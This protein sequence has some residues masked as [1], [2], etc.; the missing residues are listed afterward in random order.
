MNIQ[1]IKDRCNQCLLCARD[2]VAGAWRIVN[3]EPIL[4]APE[5]CSRCG[6][7]VAVCPRSAIFHESMDYH[8]ITKIDIDL[9]KPDVYREIV[10]GRRSIRQYKKAEVPPDIIENILK[11][12]SHSPT[13]SNKQNVAYTVISDKAILHDLSKS[14]FGFGK[15]LYEKSRKGPGKV[16]YFILKSLFPDNINRYLDPMDYYIKE[17][18]KGRD[19]ILHGAP[20]LILVHGPEKEN[21]IN[22]N[23]NIAAANIMNFAH[24]SGL[25]TC[26]IGF[27]T[28]ALKFSSPLRKKAR[29]PKNQ[30]VYAAL[31]LGY[32]AYGHSYTTSR[33]QP[34]IQW[35]LA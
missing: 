28:L 16:I 30:K 2:C 14:V 17:A 27:L 9:I 23:C 10:L 34:E 26:Y 12:A 29:I 15:S 24:S 5:L 6:H 20:V 4:V 18:D 19:Y 35:I 1:R 8:Q 32:P 31:I 13:A 7:C 21:F 25:G 22:E 11:L 3:G 33:K